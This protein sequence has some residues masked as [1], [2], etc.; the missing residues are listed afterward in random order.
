MESLEDIPGSIETRNKIRKR[1]EQ[2]YKWIFEEEG[3]KAKGRK[4][5]KPKLVLDRE[6]LLYL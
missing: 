2:G 6:D 3:G 5:D 1:W 4:I